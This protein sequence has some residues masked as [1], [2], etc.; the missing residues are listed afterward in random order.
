PSLL[1]L[2][3]DRARPAVQSHRG[4]SLDVQLPASLVGPLKQLAQS[5]QASLFMVLLAGF[6]AILGR[7]S[8]QDDIAVGSPV[9]NRPRAELEGLI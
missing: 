4:G 1:E 8:G 5:R 7:Y 9:A 3:T 2:P 6:Q